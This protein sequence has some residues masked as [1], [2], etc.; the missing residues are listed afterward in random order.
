[1]ELHCS[2]KDDVP[3]GIHISDGTELADDPFT[4]DRRRE[5]LNCTGKRRIGI[6]VLSA[7]RHPEREIGEKDERESKCGNCQHPCPA[8]LQ[9][10]RDEQ[11][12]DHEDDYGNGD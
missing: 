6:E 2:C 8:P 12:A 9:A 10:S 7:V 4:K 1:M 3:T 11:Q 5:R